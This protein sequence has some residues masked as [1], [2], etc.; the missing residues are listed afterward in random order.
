MTHM[1]YQ[2]LPKRAG[3]QWL[4]SVPR[5]SE[6]VIFPFDS[7]PVSPAGTWDAGSIILMQVTMIDTLRMPP[8][9]IPIR[10]NTAVLTGASSAK[11]IVR[12]QGCSQLFLRAESAS[13]LYF[14]LSNMPV[15]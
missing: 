13:F 4:S 2:R 14:N 6:K 11:M 10:P 7:C 15:S 8:I 9:P 1:E 12:R 3:S 5:K